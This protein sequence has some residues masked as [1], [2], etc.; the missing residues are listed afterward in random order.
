MIRTF[1]G[2]T[3]DIN[4]RRVVITEGDLSVDLWF[5]FLTGGLVVDAQSRVDAILRTTR[6]FSRWQAQRIVFCAGLAVRWI[7]QSEMS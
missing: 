4:S 1:D 7:A 2:T 6:R 5:E 3:I